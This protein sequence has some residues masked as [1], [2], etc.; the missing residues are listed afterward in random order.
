MGQS[1]LWVWDNHAHLHKDHQTK[2][3]LEMEAKW[4]KPILLL[5]WKP[6]NAYIQGFGANPGI[7]YPNTSIQG[8][9]IGKRI[10]PDCAV[11]PDQVFGDHESYRYVWV[12]VELS[13]P[14]RTG[15]DVPVYLRILDPDDPSFNSPPVDP[16]DDPDTGIHRG[17]DNRGNALFV[18]G[19]QDYFIV[20]RLNS[21]GNGIGWAKI[22]LSNLPG[23]NFKVGA[24]LEEGIRDSMRVGEGSQQEALRIYAGNQLVPE[25]DKEPRKPMRAT[26]LL[27]IWQKIFYEYDRMYRRGAWLIDGEV[28]DD[29]DDYDPIM[30][31]TIIRIEEQSDWQ[32]L[33]PG[34]EIHLFDSLNQEGEK[35]RIKRI[36][37][38][39]GNIVR[40]IVEGR[41]V[42]NY[43]KVRGGAI[44]WGDF[45]ELDFTLISDAFR[46]GYIEFEQIGHSGIL[47]SFNYGGANEGITS[48]WFSYFNQRQNVLWLVAGRR[49]LGSLTTGESWPP[50]NQS[51]VFVERLQEAFGLSWQ[52]ARREVLVHEVGHQFD[53]MG[54]D[55]PNHEDHPNWLNNDGCVML[56]DTTNGQNPPQNPNN[57]TN[58][59]AHFGLS[60]IRASLR[61][62]L[63]PLQ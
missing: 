51:F 20:I 19:T 23:D 13:L 62:S 17:G 49:R 47:P 18:G 39:I 55:W 2:P 37:G 28:I 58:D 16:T 1:L 31:E 44:G 43:A 32:E 59:I 10:F 11:P 30:N 25:G 5:T 7:D 9:G 6:V 54:R 61:G 22:K 46:I 41:V 15:Q 50:Y 48:Q 42:G 56:Y 38:P 52:P 45:F 36:E 53:G 29:G 63:Y 33:Q 60:D 35:L 4:E 27:T 12:R 34:M 26:E 8:T 3:A 40:V 24:A 57:F 14:E 21:L